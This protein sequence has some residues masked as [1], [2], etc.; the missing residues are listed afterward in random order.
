[1]RRDEPRQARLEEPD[2]G[3]AVDDEPARHQPLPPPSRHRPGRHVEPPAHRVDRQDRLGRLLGLLLDRRREVLDE[4][5]Q[6]VP[7]VA[8]FEHQRRRTPRDGSP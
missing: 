7:D 6:V 2:L 4:Q 8:A 5:P 3:P 1:M